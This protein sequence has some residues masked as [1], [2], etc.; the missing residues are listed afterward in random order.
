MLYFLYSTTRKESDDKKES[1][2]ERKMANLK[3]YEN[4]VGN[5]AFAYNEQILHFPHCF[6]RCHKAY[7]WGK[8]LRRFNLQNIFRTK[9]VAM[10]KILQISDHDINGLQL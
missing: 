6:K 4:I 3:G 8:G 2:M 7:P 1:V 9:T 10:L 5:G